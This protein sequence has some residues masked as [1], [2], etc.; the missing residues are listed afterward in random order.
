MNAPRK[1]E[2]L[3]GNDDKAAAA[4]ARFSGLGWL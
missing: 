4:I 1:V 2:R 3:L